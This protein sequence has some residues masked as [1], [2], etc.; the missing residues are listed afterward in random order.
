[1]RSRAVLAGSL[2]LLLGSWLSGCGPGGGGGTPSTISG[3][4]TSAAPA[5]LTLTVYRVEN[6]TVVPRAISIPSTTAVAMAAL[7]ALGVDAPVTVS[8]GTATVNHSSATAEQI[9][10]IV[11]TLTQFRSVQRVD[12]AGHTGLTRDDEETYAPA[13]LVD[14]PAAG[15]TVGRSITVSGTA[16]VFEATFVLELRRG[17]KLVDRKTVTASEGAPA[18]GTFTA[19]LDAP[20]AGPATIA[21]YAPSAA[22]GSPQH[23]VEVPVTVIS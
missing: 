7:H 6:G 21:A 18:R 14:S 12:V 3:T 13:I 15:A 16:R 9:A 11:F 1:M 20:S 10:E 5:P 4:G 19:T 2:A 22:D 8:G 23:R 17:G